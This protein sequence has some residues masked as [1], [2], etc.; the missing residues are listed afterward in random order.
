MQRARHLLNPRVLEPFLKNAEA[1]VERHPGLEQVAKLLGENEQLTVR[2]L[3]ILGWG[4]SR[5]AALCINQLWTSAQRVD[6]NWDAILLFDLAN[7]DRA[8]R[9]IEHAFDEAALSIACAIGKLR[10]RKKFRRR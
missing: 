2:N 7:G 10:H 6:P 1:F 9:H 5:A 8:I 4:S 3:E